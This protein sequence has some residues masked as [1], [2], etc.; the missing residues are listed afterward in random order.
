MRTMNRL[1]WAGAARLR[2]AALCIFVL[3]G[4]NGGDDH[5]DRLA[6]APALT[7]QFS[8]TPMAANVAIGQTVSLTGN[9]VDSEGHTVSAPKIT[10]A[11]DTSG[12][13]S[14]D[15][16]GLVTGVATGTAH[17]TA[18]VVAPDGSTQSQQAAISVVP[19]AVTYNLVPANPTLNL[20]YNHPTTATIT[21]L[22]S[23][24]T[25]VTAQATGW[26]W[27]SNNAAVVTPNA[28]GASATLTATH[29]SATASAS[30]TV[31]VSAVAP[32][33]SIVTGRIAVTVLP[34]YTYHIILSTTVA[35]IASDRQATVTA[36]VQRSDGTDVTSEF[37]NWQWNPT[38]GVAGVQ[39]IGIT[40]SGSSATFVSSVP[41]QFATAL[42]G[43]I[44]TNTVSV[45]AEGADRS[46]A[47]AGASLQLSQYAAY[48]L[49]GPA[50]ASG[51]LPV[52]SWTL[53][54]YHTSDDLAPAASCNLGASFDI[55]PTYSVMTYTPDS[56]LTTLRM[57]T[58]GTY[59]VQISCLRLDRA[60]IAAPM[61]ITLY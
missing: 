10:F 13:A 61:T 24:G 25:D 42:G 50:T 4:C 53:L 12:V 9:L 22:G 16:A 8:L 6:A 23:D 11:T 39:Q 15:A 51:P 48:T 28:A 1:T 41:D 20:Q 46:M 19:A 26:T 36:S 60:P 47:V 59:P 56:G 58:A 49:V 55:T 29:D 5:T 37:T 21:V 54:L 45:T 44:F 31:T 32:N 52:A 57:P 35:K 33:G 40:T 14:V 17:V 2:V 27:S 30:A 43:A 3:G 18:T 7:Y 34:H 38:S